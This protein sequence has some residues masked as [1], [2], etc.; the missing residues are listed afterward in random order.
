MLVA[1]FSSL[2][3]A[4]NAGRLR[5][6][7][8][9]SAARVAQLAMSTAPQAAA[10]VSVEYAKSGRSTCKGCSGVIASGALRLGASTPDPRGF[11]ATKWYHV[12]CFPSDASHPLGPVESINGFDSIKVRALG[13]RVPWRL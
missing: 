9:A 7:L 10:A 5:F 3:I 4:R 6:L 13:G 1:P 12:A 8:P 2:S 11:E